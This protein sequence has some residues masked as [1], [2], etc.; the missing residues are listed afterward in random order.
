MN[1][2]LETVRIRSS[3]PSQGDYV[4]INK[5]DFDPGKHVL[6]EQVELPKRGPGRPRKVEP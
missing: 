6:F 5:S 2:D 4:V 1:D 3:H